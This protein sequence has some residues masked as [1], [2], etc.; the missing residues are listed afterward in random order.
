MKSERKR[1]LEC[2]KE[3]WEA[4]LDKT[5]TILLFH[6]NVSCRFVIFLNN[7]TRRRVPY[8]VI[9]FETLFRLVS[10]LTDY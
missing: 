5:D 1:N 6:D 3:V 4:A 2:L 7:A 10:A 8:F 9:S